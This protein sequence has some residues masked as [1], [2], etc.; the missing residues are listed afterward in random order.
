MTTLAD[1][2]CASVPVESLSALGKL[3]TRAT[4]R[5][6][7]EGDRFWLRWP[8]DEEVALQVLAL[9]GVRLFI[10]RDG[11]WYTLGSRVPTSEV[12]DLGEG[13]ALAN[14]LLPAA[15]QF[16]K[17]IEDLIEPMTLQLER[18]ESP[19]PA[20]AMRCSLGALADWADTAT[21]LEL[22]SL[23]AVRCGEE[24]IVVGKTLP[25]LPGCQRYWGGRVL[26][27]LGYRP[28]PN[29]PESALVEALRL[30]LG[31]L[32]L[33]DQGTV[34]VVQRELFA[35]LTRA[36]VRLAFREMT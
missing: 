34:E 36:G 6:I 1:V 19:R 12:P 15:F 35:P 22:Q 8:G 30:H 16:Q 28:C 23:H 3:R 13:T 29:L 5:V 33:L 4:L 7:R 17:P 24:A 20:S 27:P 11:L 14:V 32:V 9:P 18:D 25:L 10:P 26:V 2:C 31:E 21:S